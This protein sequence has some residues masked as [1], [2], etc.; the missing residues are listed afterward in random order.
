MSKDPNQLLKEC[1]IAMDDVTLEKFKERE[2]KGMPIEEKVALA[3]SLLPIP[4]KQHS[5]TSESRRDSKGRD[6]STESA[7][8]TAGTNIKK[9]IYDRVIKEG[10]S[11][12]EAAIIAD[13]KP[14]DWVA[15][16]AEADAKERTYNRA[17][18]SG[19]SPAE[20]TIIAN[21]I[22]AKK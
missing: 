18:K 1:L 6:G 19:R 17:I 21:Y 8:V 5:G 10:R 3:N 22:P 13:Y 7:H 15:P 9:R 12:V 16:V 4:N 11:P 2:R 14:G 20:A